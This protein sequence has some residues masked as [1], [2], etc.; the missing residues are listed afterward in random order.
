M[1]DARVGKSTIS[2]LLLD[3]YR[4]NNI[5]LKAYY[6]GYVNKLEAYQTDTFKIPLLDFSLDNSDIILDSLQDKESSGLRLV[7]TD[8]PGQNLPQFKEFEKNIALIDNLNS[9]GYRVTFLHPI[10]YRP[11]CPNE[12]LK[13]LFDTY[14]SRADYVIVKNHYFGD[15][16]RYYDGQP[17]QEIV[18]IFKGVEL[19]LRQLHY[20]YYQKLH[21][22]GL[23]YS[24]AITVD[25]PLYVLERSLIFHWIKNF[26]DEVTDNA[27][28]VK[29]LGLGNLE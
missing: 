4:E 13:P 15:E 28:A 16:F 21:D 8:M 17:I 10:S 25:S 24:K 14:G 26:H 2:R 27:Q 6:H 29:Y 7:L 1:G 22:T 23:T 20:N 5:R 9:I 19:N 11:D 18:K 12:Y 3:L